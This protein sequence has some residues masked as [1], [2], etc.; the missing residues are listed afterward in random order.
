[1]WL[2]VAFS[3]DRYFV[4]CH[5]FIAERFCSR[6]LANVIIF[7]LF[8]VCIGY[9]IPRFFEHEIIRFNFQGPNHTLLAFN[10]TLLMDLPVS[11]LWYHVASFGGSKAF[12]LGY[13]F[14]SWMLF[15]VIAPFISL[16]VMNSFLIREV[17]RSYR[18]GRAINASERRRN[19]TNVMLISVIVLFF[20]CQVPAAINH[21][22]W[23]FI[24]E[25]TEPNIFRYLTNEIGNFLII[26]NSAINIMPY[27]L[28]GRKFRQELLGL[29]CSRQVMSDTKMVNISMNSLENHSVHHA[30]SRAAVQTTTFGSVDGRRLMKGRRSKNSSKSRRQK[31]S[32]EEPAGY[33]ANGANNLARGSACSAAPSGVSLPASTSQIS[34]SRGSSSPSISCEMREMPGPPE[35][36]H[37]ESRNVRQEVTVETFQ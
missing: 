11:I 2:T 16:A 3:A 37:R 4:I 1:M 14:V 17:R 35:D 6:M 9:N 8:L 22:L 21:V 12:R 18:R 5:P 7:L 31:L 32:G 36:N 28:F 26:L 27:Y 29:F 25:S 13:H 34:P 19:D 15:V 33:I 30:K 10:D 24:T 20:I 23:G